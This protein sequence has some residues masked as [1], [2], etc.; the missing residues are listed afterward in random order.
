MSIDRYDWHYDSAEK[1][2][3]ERNNINGELTEEQAEEVCLYASDHI[4][5]FLKWIIESG[6][7]GEESDP[8]GCEL[9]RKG[10]INGAQY[11]MN[12]CDGKFWDVDVSD[13]IRPF[14]A[15]YYESDENLY[16]NDFESVMTGDFYETISGDTEFNAVKPLID[17]AYAKF[18]GGD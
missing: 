17:K 2:Y 6:F 11:L 10:E 1:A 5:L 8:E 7:E 16:F 18:K 12:Y 14:V 4:G 15:W 9:V 13:E 3:R